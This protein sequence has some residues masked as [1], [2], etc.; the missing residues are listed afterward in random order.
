VTAR[1]D[2][3][4]SPDGEGGGP[5]VREEKDAW[6]RRLLAARR[7]L[8]A[9]VRADRAAA[10]AA[11]AVRLADGTS[12]PVCAYLPV[13]SEPGT[14]SLVEALREA[15]HDVLLPVVPP[16]PGPLD[17]ARFDGVEALGPGPL[18]L[19]E[20]VGPRLG[21]ATVTQ[22]GL[23][24]VPALAADRDGRRL[25]RGGGFYDRTLPLARTATPLVVV[26]NDDELV[27]RVPVEP[28]DRRVTGALL[29]DAGVIR[30]GNSS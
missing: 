6:R 21:P 13:G 10:L 25:G 8:P 3:P 11:G 26:L 18:G 9:A 12:G 24:L 22:A 1:A 29:P 4:P 2:V 14:P 5:A 16:A 15:G 27:A 19:R 28:H 23:M 17:W 20:P 7:A 30:L